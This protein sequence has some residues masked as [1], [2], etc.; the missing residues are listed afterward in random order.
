VVL[1]LL[2]PHPEGGEHFPEEG[3]HRSAICWDTSTEWEQV[4]ARPEKRGRGAPR[5]TR[6]SGG[7]CAGVAQGAGSAQA[8]QAPHGGNRSIAWEGPY[9]V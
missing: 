7:R 9:N 3:Q 4:G 8:A 2:T 6:N 1:V 5:D